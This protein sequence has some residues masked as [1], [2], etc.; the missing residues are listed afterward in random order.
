V[1]AALKEA[2]VQKEEI[3]WLASADVKADEAGLIEAARILGVPLRL[4]DGEEI[5]LSVKPFAH[6]AFVQ[7]KVNV[8]AV[9]EAAALLAGRRT[10]LILPKRIF[11][12]VTVALARENFLWSASAPE[13][14]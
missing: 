7:E 2:G 14:P 5:R 3:R 12:G 10:R 8:P 4:V 11:A 6:S 9:A 1:A 13:D